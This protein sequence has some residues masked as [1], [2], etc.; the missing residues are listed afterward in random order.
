MS[1]QRSPPAKKGDDAEWENER[2]G[3]LWTPERI[4]LAVPL[5]GLGERALAYLID[6]GILFLATALLWFIYNTFWGDAIEA[7]GALSGV[8]AV[9]LGLLIFGAAVSYDVLFEVLGGGRTPGKRALKLRVLHASGRPPDTLVSLL[10]NVMRLV[11]ILPFGYAVGTVALFLTGT[12]R[13]G[14]LVA[15]TFVVTERARAR[16]PFV[17]LRAA[18]SASH[19]QVAV[20]RRPWSDDQLLRAIGM[21]ERTAA[22]DKRTAQTLCARALAKIDPE[23]AHSTQ[24]TAPADARAVLAAQVLAHADAP[25][26]IVVSLRRLADAEAS[27]VAS[28]KALKDGEST[29]A[30]VER[31]DHAIRRAA[32]E[33]MRAARLDVPAR[34]LESLS[35]AL[36]D[37]ERRRVPKAPLVVTVKKLFLFEVPATVWAERKLIATAGAILGVGLFVGGSLAFADAELARALIGDDIAA[38]IEGGA[39]WTNSIEREGQFATASVQI[40]LNNV[41]V[42]LRVFAYGLLGGVGTMLGLLSNGLQ[43]GA[44]F[45]Y[46]LQ[47][48]TADTL[49]RFVLAHGPVELTMISVAGAGGMCLGRALVSPGRRTRLQALREEGARGAK[50]V[51]AAS[52]GFLCIGCV[53]GF[54]SPG[55][56]FPWQVNATIG[57]GLLALFW[58]WVRAFSR[59]AKVTVR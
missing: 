34:H 43:I 24:A 13:L 29:L 20:T 56:L 28:L 10:R 8:A 3:R 50:L 26:G 23:L 18:S 6:L 15:D 59:P 1:P 40:I 58:F 38:A 19:A 35:L 45:G 57:L 31:V 36:L 44:T 49:L 42:G 47:L 55:A 46:A 51:V 30:D 4:Q 39:S 7:L 48:D 5:A 53:E 21:V 22:V 27:L 2:I 25:S 12:R 14:D 33:L 9:L 16:D 17:F 32:S 37:A 41:G 11:D 54:I 52:L